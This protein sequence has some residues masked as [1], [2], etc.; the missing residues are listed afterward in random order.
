VRSDDV[1]VQQEF[2]L[3][4]AASAGVT[5]GSLMSS[6]ERR[7]RERAPD[8]ELE[9]GLILL[10]READDGG[11]ARAVFDGAI[12]L[13]RIE[14]SDDQMRENTPAIQC[15]ASA[16]RGDDKSGTVELRAIVSCTSPCAMTTAFTR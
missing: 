3:S 1:T 6:A 2:A 13:D 11:A 16:V 8:R 12:A 14:V 9:V 4:S 5:P 10:P 15:P 7:W